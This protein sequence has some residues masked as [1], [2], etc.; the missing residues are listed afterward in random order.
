VIEAVLDFFK[1]GNLLAKVN[2]IVI[3]LVPKVLNPKTTNELRPIYKAIIKRMC[4]KLI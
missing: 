1:H 2:A 4:S 3:T